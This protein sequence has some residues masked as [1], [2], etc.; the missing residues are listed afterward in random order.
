MHQFNVEPNILWE[1]DNVDKREQME[2][3]QLGQL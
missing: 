2:L 1:I 3:G